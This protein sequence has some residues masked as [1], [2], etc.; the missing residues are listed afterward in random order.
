MKAMKRPWW[1]NRGY[2]TIIVML[3]V[4]YRFTDEGLDLLINYVINYRIEA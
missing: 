1:C 2:N 4:L 3:K